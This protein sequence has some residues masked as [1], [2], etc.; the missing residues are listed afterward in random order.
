M[1][2]EPTCQYHE[3]C[4]KPGPINWMDERIAPSPTCAY[5]S[6]D[7][8]RRGYHHG[9]SQ[10]MDDWRALTK[11][12]YIRSSEI[13]NILGRFFDRALL[14]WRYARHRGDRILPP[15]AQYPD[16]WPEIRKRIIA[17]DE[18]CVVCD[19]THRMEVDHIIAVADG[20]LPEDDN[21]RTLCARCHAERRRGK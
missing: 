19:S 9:Y 17:R 11:R 14:A 21:L 13:W 1:N 8:Y 4:K 20:G 16:P 10:A 5:S 12:G 6:E 15:R 18:C 3:H 2:T 7:N